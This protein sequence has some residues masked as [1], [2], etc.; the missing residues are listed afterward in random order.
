MTKYSFFSFGKA[1]QMSDSRLKASSMRKK[2]F[3][4]AVV[5]LSAASAQADPNAALTRLA[6]GF[7]FPVGKPNADGY[8][9]SRGFTPHGH[10]GEDW[11]G[12]GGSGTDFRDPVYAIGHGVVTL[13]REFRRSWGN[14]VVIRPAFLADG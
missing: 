9:I 1:C 13:A 7:D 2:L 14:V 10:L 11:V 12:Q 5:G 4:A 6:D 3:V 8:R